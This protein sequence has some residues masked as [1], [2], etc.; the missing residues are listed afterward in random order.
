MLKPLSLVMFVL[1]FFTFTVPNFVLASE[2]EEVYE[3]GGEFH[4]IDIEETTY[5]NYLIAQSDG[6]TCPNCST[7][8]DEGVKFCQ[9][10]GYQFSEWQ[11]EITTEGETEG[12][13]CPDC[14]TFNEKDA[15]SCNEC[16]FPLTS[17][18]DRGTDWGRLKPVLYVL[19]VVGAVLATALLWVGFGG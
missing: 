3:G 12:W 2:N 14:G 18:V 6:W 11:P 7:Q 8:N 4:P 16:R 13:V 15:K 19:A 5:Q 9:E 17:K 1:T 10:C